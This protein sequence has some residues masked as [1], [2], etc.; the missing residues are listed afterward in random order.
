MATKP[1]AK[2]KPKAPSTPSTIAYIRENY[3]FLAGFLDIPDLR[4]I[5][6]EAGRRSQKGTPV[7]KEWIQGKMYATP[8]WKKTA[9]VTRNW[10]ALN[11]TDPA[12]AKQ[13]LA[14]TKTQITSAATAAGVTLT[15]DQIAK[16]ALNVNKFGWSE[17]QV[18]SAIGHQLV[19]N[20][21]K[22]AQGQ[23]GLTVDKLKEMSSAYLVPVSDETLQKWARN[24]V[25]GDVD[26]AAFETYAKEQAKS[27]FPSLSA[28]IDAGVTVND[29]VDPYREQAAKVLEISPDEVDF[30]DPKWRKA[31]DQVDPKTGQRTA[32]SL[33]DWTTTMRTDSQ[34]G[35]DK[36]KGARAEAASLTSK[37]GEMFG[38][39]G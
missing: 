34:Y 20:P 25:G 1:K 23:A 29:Y 26:L 31:V 17:Q 13:R 35:Y 10:I 15:P 5:L 21:D 14:S 12:T 28:A 11:G 22:A 2:A 18:Q 7:S 4:K 24:V 8:W 39:L 16:Y 36:T 6:I 30:M 27:L 3:G 38:V 32:L 19:Y 33:A 9:E 37:L